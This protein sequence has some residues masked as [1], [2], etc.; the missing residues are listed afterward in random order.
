MEVAHR[1]LAD[2]QVQRLAQSHIQRA[3][4]AANR[5]GQRAFDANQKLLECLHGLIRQPGAELRVCF[6]AGKDLHPV[7]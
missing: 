2:I 4:A 7:E 6:F 3:N 1:S 5:R